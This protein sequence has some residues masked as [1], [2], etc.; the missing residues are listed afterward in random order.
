MKKQF[1]FLLLLV[2]TMYLAEAQPLPA[3]T[4]QPVM[5]GFLLDLKGEPLVN[6]YSK[7]TD[8]SPFFSDDWLKGKL[9]STDGKVYEN[10]A[11]KINL[12]E[13]DLHYLNDDGK[14][15]ILKTPIRLVNLSNPVTGQSFDF[16]KTGTACN[17]NSNIWYQVLD[18]GSTWLL[19]SQVKQLFEINT[20]GSASTEEKI[21]TN[22]NYHLYHKQECTRV[23][24]AHELWEML[25]KLESGFTEKTT[26]KGGA[27]KTEE[28]LIRLNRLYNQKSH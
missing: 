7:V 1:L 13:N 27:K 14:E 15:L 8:G 4:T 18:T 21:S 16:I 6:K 26:V 24:N 28:E 11:L 23:K 22:V 9:I 25:N 20:Y 19:K 12:A 5:P 17:A 10:L 3:V 2:F